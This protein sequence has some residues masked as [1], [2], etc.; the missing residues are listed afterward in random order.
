MR[1]LFLILTILFSSAYAMAQNV[2]QGPTP[3]TISTYEKTTNTVT[4]FGTEERAVPQTPDPLSANL[5]G[6]NVAAKI[7]P[8]PLVIRA[9]EE[10]SN[11]IPPS[12]QAEA[13]GQTNT[14]TSRTD[15]LINTGI[16]YADEGDYKEAERAYLRARD[17][18]PSNPNIR[19]SLSTLYIQMERYK[20][21]ADLL[22][23]L[24]AE[25][26]ENAMVQ[27]NLAW[28][29]S[30]GGVMKNGKLALRH[31]REALLI[32]P[33]TPALWNTLAEAYYVSGLYDKALR[34]SEFAFELLQMQ[35]G[36][37]EEDFRSFQAQYQKIYRAN[38][39]SK[40][41]LGL[42]TEK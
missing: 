5:D 27:N 28:I 40:S 14:N 13:T 1:Y 26:P 30:A 34:S 7:G 24:A 11:T 29:Y 37:K 41:L 38:E 6:T 21:A 39:A 10:T 20:E 4:K 18:D 22:N 25:F 36:T 31:A 42:D 23:G 32:A 16:Q 17:N 19:I 3:L 35:Q 15:F 33:Y 2:P 8:D 12:V 9:Y